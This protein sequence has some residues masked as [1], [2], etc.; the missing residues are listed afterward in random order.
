M[1]LLTTRDGLN[2]MY[3][4]CVLEPVPSANIIYGHWRVPNHE[5][6]LIIKEPADGHGVPPPAIGWEGLCE[7]N[8]DWMWRL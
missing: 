4:K 6:V 8:C 3:A 5:P 2:R 7:I 1:L